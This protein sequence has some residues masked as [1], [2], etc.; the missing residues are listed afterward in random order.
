M[1]YSNKSIELEYYIREGIS[2]V[3]YDISDLKKHFQIRASLYRLLGLIPNFFEGKDILEI[4]PGSGHNSIYTASLLP[5]TYDLVEPN[6]IGCKDIIKIFKNLSIKHTKPN[7]LQQSLDDFKS[8]KLYDIAITEGWPGGFLDYDKSMLNKISSFVKTGG[9][10]LISFF[11]PIGGMSTYLRRLIGHRLI[12]E[13]NQMKQK[14]SILKK[15][16]SPHL[17]KLSSMSRS[18]DHWIQDS[19]LNPYI[20]VAHNTPLLCTQILDT[21][22]EIYNSVPKFGNDWRW[23]KSLHGNQ[24]KFNE[25][26]LSEYD[27]ISH[28]MIDYR[29]NGIKR[30][31]EKNIELEKFCFD[32]ATV[33][34]NNEN[35]GHDAYMDQVQP[36]LSKIINNVKNDLAQYTL[37]GLDEANTLL[38]KKIV[39]SNDITKMSYFSSLFGREQCYLSLSNEQ[40]QQ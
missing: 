22:F 9:V 31:K 12:S 10:M 37:N 8:H 24:R 36:L 14:T 16:F 11:P 7:L 25:N 13:K 38:K 32:F 17:D 20:C 1:D 39:E 27:S 30:S 5:K 2:P 33:T 15:A 23:Y 40:L 34:K 4:A 29:M 35:L 26:F 6:P 3:S 19:I 18:Q 21:K 28:C